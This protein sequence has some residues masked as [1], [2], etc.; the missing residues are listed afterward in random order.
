MFSLDGV[1]KASPVTLDVK[2]CTKNPYPL[3][4]ASVQNNKWH[5]ADSLVCCCC[6][7]A[8]PAVSGDYTFKSLAEIWDNNSINTGQRQNQSR[9]VSKMEWLFQNTTISWFHWLFSEK[10]KPKQPT[11]N[12]PPQNPN[13]TYHTAEIHR[14][15]M[16]Q[17]GRCCYD[18][19]WH[20]YSTSV[21]FDRAFLRLR[22]SL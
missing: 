4:F 9:A 19:Q 17:H 8:K 1:W 21:I 16:D 2:G 12:Q 6:R 14:S 20:R 5:N 15:C 18:T 13:K 22:T 3:L 7:R 10:E 11:K